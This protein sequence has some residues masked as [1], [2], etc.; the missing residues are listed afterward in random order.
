MASEQSA[1][2]WHRSEFGQY[3]DAPEEP[4]RFYVRREGRRYTLEVVRTIVVAGV[5]VVKP[6]TNPITVSRFH[7]TAAL[8]KATADAYVTEPEGGTLSRI[9]RASN[10][11]YRADTERSV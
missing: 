1:L 7:D 3:A 4:I 10:R 8:A 11:A 2:A 5:T 9:T 6:G